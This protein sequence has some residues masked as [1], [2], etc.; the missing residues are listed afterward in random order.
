M[1]KTAREL[2]IS[3]LVIPDGQVKPGVPLEHWTWIGQYIVDMKPNVIINIG[4]FA[5]MESLSFYD[6]GKATFEGRRYKEDIKAAGK[7]MRMLL[8]PLKAY[9][10]KQRADKK[11]LYKP[12]M[13]LTLGNHEE[14]IAR[15]GENSSELLGVIGYDDLPYKDWEV[16]PYLEPIEIDGI[17]YAHYFVNPTSLKKPPVG[18]TL[19]N[20]LMKL[21]HSFTMGHQQILQYGLKYGVNGCIQGLVAGSCYQHD[22]DYLGPQGNDYWRGI[23]LKHRVQG[24]NYD[25]CFVSLD[26]LRDRYQTTKTKGE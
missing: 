12:R 17:Y 26:Y 6:R 5:D 13:V 14:R 23:I 1:K 8:A 19:D 2:Q 9:N 3:H 10:K 22:E 25:P 21:G 7:A 20:K 15:V 18:G 16:I 11:K 4:D 24:G